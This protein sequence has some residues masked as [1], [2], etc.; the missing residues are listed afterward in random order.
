M[1]MLFRAYSILSL[2]YTLFSAYGILHNINT[3][4]IVGLLFLMYQVLFV[5]N[6]KKAAREFNRP[7]LSQFG[8]F[9]ILS[10]VLHVVSIGINIAPPIYVFLSYFPTGSFYLTPYSLASAIVE[11]CSIALQLKAWFSIATFFQA[12]EVPAIQGRGMKWTKLL[13]AAFLIQLGEVI[14]LAIPLALII[15]VIDYSTASIIVPNSAI[16]FE[17]IDAASLIFWG[18]LT[19]VGYFK[20]GDAFLS[21]ETSKTPE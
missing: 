5:S 14:L 2:V 11:V 13:I 12:N 6:A 8:T 15:S 16:L 3:M 21:L 20:V 19:L 17:E 18:I 9:I 4:G 10:L 1:G 7:V